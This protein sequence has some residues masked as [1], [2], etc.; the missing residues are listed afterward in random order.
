MGPARIIS[1]F[2]F[3]CG[4]RSFLW[5]GHC[6]AAQATYPRV[7]RSG[8]LLLSYLVL[9]RMGFTL[10]DELLRPRCALTAPFH[11]YLRHE[12]AGGIFSVALSVKPALSESPRPL[13][14]ML[15]CGDRTFLPAAAA[16]PRDR[17]TTRPNR[18]IIIVAEV[19]RPYSVRDSNC[20]ILTT[21][22]SG[23][24]ARTS[25]VPP[26]AFPQLARVLRYI[27]VRRSILETSDCFT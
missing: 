21:S 18:P 4:R 8:P 10:P 3:P 7:E 20:V 24:A 1:R 5:A 26:I 6:W 27:S 19:E 17:A 22:P 15:P 11:P 14:G 9:L 25:N 13:A 12:A 16:K 23:N 2:L